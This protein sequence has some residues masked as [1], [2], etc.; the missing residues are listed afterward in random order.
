MSFIAGRYVITYGAVAIGQVRDPN[1]EHFV[2]KQLIV[3]DNFG[4]SPQDAVLQGME[5]FVDFTLMEFDSPG[6]LDLFWPY[7]NVM[8]LPGVVG[9]LDVQNTIARALVMAPLAGTPAADVT[10][11]PDNS[12]LTTFNAAYAV[13]A[14]GFPVRMLKAPALRE[15]PIRLRLYPDSANNNRLYF[16]S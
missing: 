15:I 1:L 6:A 5:A 2:N 7:D 16:W 10:A 8:G 11:G 14:E 3:G 9:R 12:A 13:L 4:T